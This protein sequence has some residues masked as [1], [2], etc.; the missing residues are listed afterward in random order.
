MNRLMR[1]PINH[2]FFDLF[3]RFK[4]FVLQK[5]RLIRIRELGGRIFPFYKSL[6]GN[7]T[8]KSARKNSKRINGQNTYFYG[9]KNFS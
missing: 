7:H 5:F 4:F 6:T 9:N 8:V 2:V 3:V 1:F